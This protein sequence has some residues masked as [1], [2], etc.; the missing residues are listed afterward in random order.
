MK[1]ILFVLFCCTVFVIG[2]GKKQ[3]EPVQDED[4]AVADTQQQEQETEKEVI[5]P[6]D[7]IPPAD[8]VALAKIDNISEET[9]QKD[10]DDDLNSFSAQEK[11]VFIMGYK[12]DKKAEQQMYK[13]AIDDYTKILA[14]QENPWTYG[15]RGTAKKA[16]G[17]F[18]GAMADLDKAIS[19]GDTVSWIYTER[20]D[21]KARL[22]DKQGA[23]ADYEASLKDKEAWKY[24]KIAE[25]KKELGDT[26]GAEAAMKK[27]KEL[28]K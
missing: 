25:L 1:K 17:D 10:I 3:E 16:I 14:I 15:R 2:C 11:E 28:G 13:E 7:N 5:N 23:I 18:A 4:F 19:F 8:P 22:G 26:A 12:A 6:I 20:A 9:V 27:A 24:E 21:L